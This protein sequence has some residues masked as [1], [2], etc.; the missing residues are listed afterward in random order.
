MLLVLVWMQDRVDLLHCLL[1]VLFDWFVAQ[2]ENRLVELG[3][4]GES[5]TRRLYYYRLVFV[6]NIIEGLNERSTFQILVLFRQFF[7]ASA[8]AWR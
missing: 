4:A 8:W 6:H 7:V 5:V 1:V 3:C 2:G